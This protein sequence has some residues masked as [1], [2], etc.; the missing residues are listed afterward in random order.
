MCRNP[1]R[2]S[3]RHTQLLRKREAHLSKLIFRSIYCCALHFLLSH[4]KCDKFHTSRCNALLILRQW[5]S[6]S[7]RIWIEFCIHFYKCSPQNLN[8]EIAVES[9]QKRR[10]TLQFSSITTFNTFSGNVNASGWSSVGEDQ[11]IVSFS[12]V[13]NNIEESWKRRRLVLSKW[14]P[15]DRVFQHYIYSYTRMVKTP[16]VGSQ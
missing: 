11:T 15:N 8:I 5:P 13:Y 7:Y 10:Q 6:K 3:R 14:G 1:P 2:D 4:T 12:I 16:P 9:N